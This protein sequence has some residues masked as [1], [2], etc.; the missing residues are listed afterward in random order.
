[1]LGSSVYIA[2]WQR[3]AHRFV[4]RFREELKARPFGPT[5]VSRTRP[6]NPSSRYTATRAAVAYRGSSR[7]RW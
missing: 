1:V 4:D 2:F 6:N 3:G 5:A 7:I